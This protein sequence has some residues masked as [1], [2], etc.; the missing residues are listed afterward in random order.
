MTAYH[1]HE[2]KSETEGMGTSVTRIQYSELAQLD[3]SLK[4]SV[5]VTNT[6]QALMSLKSQLCLDAVKVWGCATNSFAHGHCFREQ[7]GFESLKHLRK[8]NHHGIQ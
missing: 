4:P 1:K 5:L 7:G 3:P 8:R 6:L 2:N